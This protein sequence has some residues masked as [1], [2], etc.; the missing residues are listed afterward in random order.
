MAKRKKRV[1]ELQHIS[2]RSISALKLPKVPEMS[3]PKELWSLLLT[4]KSMR[5]PACSC[6]LYICT[7]ALFSFPTHQLNRDRFKASQMISDTTSADANS[8]VV[9]FLFVLKCQKELSTRTLKR[10]LTGKFRCKDIIFGIDPG[11]FEEP[12]T[13]KLGIL[14]KTVCTAK[15]EQCLLPRIPLVLVWEDNDVCDR[16]NCSG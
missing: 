13:A 12:N 2:Q 7:T 10:T 6:K 1:I 5:H 11:F 4:C 14:A 16:R 3:S 15:L 9:Q 8:F